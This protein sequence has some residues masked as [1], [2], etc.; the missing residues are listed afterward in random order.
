MNKRLNQKVIVIF[1]FIFSLPYLSQSQER[2][3]SADSSKTWFGDF[4]IG[5]EIGNA[6]VA[7]LDDHR[8]SYWDAFVR[9]RIYKRWSV[10]TSYG[11]EK[12]TYNRNDWNIYVEGNFLK[13]GVEFGF[14]QTKN[15][16]NQYLIGLRYASSS[17][18]QTINQF[19]IRTN[20][21]TDNTFGSLPQGAV[22]TQWIEFV[23]GAQ[24]EL[25]KSGFFAS[26]AFT[27]RIKLRETTQNNVDNLYTPGF[28]EDINNRSFGFNWSIFYRIPIR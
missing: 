13:F 7:I 2:D 25:F 3:V 1:L 12:H 19:V 21:G 10:T 28:G 14:P 27:P 16:N 15:I 26:V 5:V 11:L 20:A 24:V 4:F 23:V 18:D 9:A 6:L 17:F 22:Q 8:D